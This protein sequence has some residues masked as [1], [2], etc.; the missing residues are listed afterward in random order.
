MYSEKVVYELQLYM[1][2]WWHMLYGIKSYSPMMP[3]SESVCG[4]TIET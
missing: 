3:V 2:L 1:Y 4:H